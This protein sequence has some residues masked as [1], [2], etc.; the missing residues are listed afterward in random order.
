[1]IGLLCFV[2]AALAS[3]FKLG[4]EVAQSSVAP[5][6]RLVLMRGV[7]CY[8]SWRPAPG[9]ADKRHLAY[10]TG[11]W[12]WHLADMKV[13]ANVRFAPTAAFRRSDV[14]AEAGH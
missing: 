8:N 10:P 7:R 1:M 12:I 3:P 4:F 13:S 14:M 5:T 9:T 6:L 11:C 2:L